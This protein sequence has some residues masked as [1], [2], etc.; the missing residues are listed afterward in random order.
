MR[1]RVGLIDSCGAAPQAIAG[2]RFIDGAGGVQKAAPTTDA[3]GHGTRIAGLLMREHDQ[4]GLL[5]AQVFVDSGIAS[6]AAVAA[7]VDWCVAEGGNLL[8]LSLGLS[9]DRAVLAGAVARALEQGCLV[10]ASTPAR[11]APVY[12]AAYAGVISATGD[13]RCAPGE[14]SQ[15]APDTFGGCPWFESASGRAQGASI[16]AAAITHLLIGAARAVSRAEALELL[17][18]RARYQGP[19][20]R[21]N[22]M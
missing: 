11:G 13:A 4:A 21:R 16:G 12:P 5:L 10:I 20:R 17:A 19:E 8:H 7:A 2:A 6:A 22:I 3:T 1:W 14:L 18:A 15:L 9:A